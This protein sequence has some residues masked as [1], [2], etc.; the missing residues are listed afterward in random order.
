MHVVLG[1][2]GSCVMVM[3]DDGH[4]PSMH[5]F[6]RFWCLLHRGTSPSRGVHI[7]FDW[8]PVGEGVCASLVVFLSAR[9]CGYGV[10]SG[11][12]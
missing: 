11:V 10:C 5:L 8:M 3:C 2:L 4:P 7:Q 6:F 12:V 9:A 1:L